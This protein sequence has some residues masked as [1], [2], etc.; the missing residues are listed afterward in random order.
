MPTRLHRV[1]VSVSDLPR[2]RRFYVDLLGLDPQERM[3][4]AQLLSIGDGVEL[5]LHQRETLPSDLSIS[6]SFGV[7]DLDGTCARWAAVGGA[8]VD[9]PADQPWGERMAVVRDPDG[10][11]ICLVQAG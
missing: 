4:D 8:I 7:E 2:S 1:I 3:G 10:H 9:E 6:A 11:L 5:L